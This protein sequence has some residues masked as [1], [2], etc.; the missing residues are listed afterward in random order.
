MKLEEEIKRLKGENIRLRNL[1]NRM[2][3]NEVKIRDNLKSS[4]NIIEEMLGKE[5]NY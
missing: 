5:V 3:H 4:M 1:I 2:L